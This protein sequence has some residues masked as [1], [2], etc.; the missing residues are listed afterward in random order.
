[1]LVDVRRVPNDFADSDKRGKR[2]CTVCAMK[3][4]LAMNRVQDGSVGFEK[5]EWCGEADHAS[6]SDPF[7]MGGMFCAR[8][9]RAIVLFIKNR[10]QKEQFGGF[11]CTVDN[12]TKTYAHK[13]G[14]SRHMKQKHSM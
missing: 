13:N 12:C 5:C 8:C 6:L 14:L 2:C 11:C 4:R 9:H 10:E 1:M 7:N 3:I